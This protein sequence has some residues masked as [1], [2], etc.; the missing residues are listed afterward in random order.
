[1]AAYVELLIDQGTTFTNTLTIND[2]VTN[3]PINIAS[4]SVTSQL[5]RSYYSAN[6]SGTFDCSLTDA[7]NGV[8]TMAMS[9]ANTSNLKPGRYVFDVHALIDNTHSRLLEGIITVSPGVTR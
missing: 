4:Y 7:A 3:N 8:I 6:A 5:R 1:M 9:A 2:D